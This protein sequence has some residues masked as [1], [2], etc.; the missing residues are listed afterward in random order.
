M[1]FFPHLR[2]VSYKQNLWTP[3]RLYC[4]DVQPRSSDQENEDVKKATVT[5][6]RG[7]WSDS[8]VALMLK[9]WSRGWR[10]ETIAKYLNRKTSSVTVKLKT[11]VSQPDDEI[12]AQ[13]IDTV[14]LVEQW[15]EIFEQRAHAILH[16]LQQEGSYPAWQIRLSEKSIKIWHDQIAPHVPAEVKSVLAYPY[17]PDFQVLRELP[18]VDTNWRGVYAWLLEP[19]G[20]LSP[21]IKRRG[22]LYV[23]S[24]SKLGYGLLG[25]KE[26][27]LSGNPRDHIHR[28]W[29]L[30]IR[31]G[32]KRDRK[33]IELLSIPDEQDTPDTILS[34]RY[35]FV[36]A[37]AMFTVW[38][39]AI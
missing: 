6:S 36:L 20:S 27:H 37:E 34:T 39:Q 1:F 35:L 14:F 2:Y 16:G 21:T 17:A 23:G 24:A 15:D 8:E 9:Y 11:L 22:F 10:R 5:R 38:L 7:R 31:H 25:R 13:P 3:R 4:D 29:D 26:Q 33:F 28:L 12:P 19:R 18:D 30:S 32:L